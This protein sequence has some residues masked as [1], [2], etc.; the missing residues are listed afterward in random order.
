VH[1]HL[2]THRSEGAT[3][4]GR[5]GPGPIGLAHFQRRF[6][7]PFPCTRRIFNRKSLE[8]PPFAQREPF[9]LGGHPQARER[10]GRS[11]EEDRPTRRKRSQVE[12]KEDTLGSV[13]MI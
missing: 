12:K 10:G 2:R 6:S 13:T 8:A 11:L 5:D 7:P 3:E 9:A 1:N 4:P